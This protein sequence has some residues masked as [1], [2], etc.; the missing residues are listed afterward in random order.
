MLGMAQS[1]NRMAWPVPAKPTN[2]IKGLQ[3]P[4]NFFFNINPSAKGGGPIHRIDN[5][6]LKEETVRKEKPSYGTHQ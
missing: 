3:S 6:R 4:Y 5:C 2:L 1:P